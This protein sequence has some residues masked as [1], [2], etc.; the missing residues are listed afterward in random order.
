[1]KG[2]LRDFTNY[3]VH[4]VGKAT[5]QDIWKRLTGHEKLQ[6][7]LSLESPMTY[8]SLPTHE[9]VILPFRFLNNLQIHTIGDNSDANEIV[10][11]FMGR[12]FPKRRTIFLDAEKAL[13]KAMHPKYNIELFKNYPESKDGL[14]HRKYNSLS[15]TIMDPITLSYEKG[16][17]EG[18][19][20]HLGGDVINVLDNKTFRLNKYSKS[21]STNNI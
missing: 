13:I 8:G 18:G 9:I 16:E 5:E 15:Y 21:N 14:N 19:L 7:I 11:S 6:D 4:Y 3:Y 1:V 2:D 12:N 17:I 20:H 10:D